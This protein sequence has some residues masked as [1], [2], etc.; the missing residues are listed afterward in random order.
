MAKAS[1]AKSAWRDTRGGWQSGGGWVKHRETLSAHS[2][3]QNNVI[4]RVQPQKNSL[5]DE[6]KT[7]YTNMFTAMLFKMKE[8]ARA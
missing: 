3:Y 5:K 4:C 1:V 8:V 2:L 7:S 6:G